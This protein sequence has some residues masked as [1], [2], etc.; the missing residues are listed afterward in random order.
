MR[1]SVW[2]F[3][4]QGAQYYQMGRE[5]FKE[6]PVFREF[7]EKGDELAKPLINQSLIDVIYQERSNRFDPF[8]RLLYSHPALLL[9]ECALA[10]MLKQ[11]GLRPDYL[12]GYS[13][14]EY[15]C[16][17]VSGAAPFGDVLTAVI[18]EAEL[19][20]YCA[21]PGGMLAILDS[22]AIVDRHGGEFR[23]CVVAARNF[24]RSFVV[25]GRRSTLV[26]LQG[27][28]KSVGVNTAE[29]PVDY[30]FHSPDM[31]CLLDP[32]RLVLNQLNF[33]PPGIPIISTAQRGFLKEVSWQSLQ[34]ATRN[35]LD[36]MET[37]RWLESTGQYLYVDLG[38][39]GSMATATKYILSK[40]SG[41]EFVILSSPFGHEIENLR[42]LTQK[43]SAD[44][45]IT[46]T[47]D[48]PRYGV[49]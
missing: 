46:G 24:E 41:S 47:A 8:H 34:A 23:D 39:S 20:E 16:L 43:C 12:L 30:S 48:Q 14:G 38:P 32:C 18:K 27:F 2:M 33:R 1:K 36:L 9:F 28:L 40:N 37:I 4:G 3:P 10:E 6:E 22:I 11:R 42:A 31:N 15:A 35:R 17:V 13:L 26:R 29:L 21:P 45:K 44:Q 5:L 7:V 19:T 49:F 25:S